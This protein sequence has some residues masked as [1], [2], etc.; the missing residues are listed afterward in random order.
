M[1]TASQA[2][3]CSCKNARSTSRS[4]QANRA[5]SPT[6]RDRIACGMVI[7]P[8]VY[9]QG[10]IKLYQCIPMR[11]FPTL[12]SAQQNVSA[13]WVARP[14]GEFAHSHLRPKLLLKLLCERRGALLHLRPISSECQN[15]RTKSKSTYG[16]NSSFDMKNSHSGQSRITLDW[17]ICSLKMI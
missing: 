16:C 15:D 12:S 9:P 1:P 7:C 4:W 17:N 10:S 13:H 8:L 2:L 3:N 6:Q 14:C 5:A 11:P